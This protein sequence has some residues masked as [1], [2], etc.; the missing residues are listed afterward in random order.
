[1]DDL[2][3]DQIFNSSSGNTKTKADVTLDDQ[4]ESK[5][6]RAEEQIVEEGDSKDTTNAKAGKDGDL[7][8]IISTKVLGNVGV[9]AEEYKKNSMP[10]SHNVVKDLFV[11]G[12]LGKFII[13][14][15]VLIQ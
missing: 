12:F 9:I 11:D 5:R 1:M 14:I 15:Y 2:Q 7:S 3:S 6:K 4:R 8:E 10:Y 13:F